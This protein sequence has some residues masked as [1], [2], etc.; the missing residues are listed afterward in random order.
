MHALQIIDREGPEA[1]SATLSV[2][3]N[4]LAAKIADREMADVAIFVEHEPVFTVGRSV[5]KQEGIEVNGQTIPWV[6]VGRGGKATFHGPGQ[7]VVYPILDLERH[8]KDIHVYLRR[9]EQVGI[10]CLKEFGIDA[11]TR[12][13]LTGIWIRAGGEG[14]DRGWKKI[15]SLGVGVKRWVSYHGIAL[16]VGVD[17]NYFRAIHACEHDGA[18]MTSMEDILGVAVDMSEV[19]RAFLDAMLKE[20]EFELETEISD[21][22]EQ[23]MKRRARPKWL[24]VKAPGSPE[25]M[26]TQEIVR[27]LDLVTVCEEA[28][29]PNIGECWAHA[30]AT[31]MIMGD[32]CTRRCSFCSVKDGTLSELQPLDPMEP[33][34]VAQAI[35]RLALKHVVITSVNRDDLPDMGADHFHKV[36]KAIKHVNAET[37]IELLIPDMRGKRELVETILTSGAVKVL[38]HNVETVPSMYREVRPGSSFKRSLN[39]L[40]WAKEAQPLVRTK[41]GLMVG[42]GETKDEVCEVMDALRESKVQI[43]TIGQYLQPSAKQLPVRRFVPPEEFAMYKEEGLARGFLHVESGPLVRSSYH[44]WQHTGENQEKSPSPTI[45]AAL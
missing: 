28:H 43:L 16:N 3:E 22:P 11:D 5:A 31:F 2:Q 21:L 6:E 35:K 10:R 17:L 8:G 20:F 13:G 41:S 4:L 26:K 30:S 27:E 36:V 42:L 9:L 7:L 24:K 1:Y 34:R 39:I 25:F 32:L 45:A 44:A 37:D 12:E 14:S 40:R 23:K 33:V 15:A 18:V 38:N 29:C 19:K